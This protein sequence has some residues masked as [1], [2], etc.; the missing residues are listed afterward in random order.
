MSKTD[1]L[2]EVVGE[3]SF[4]GRT[5]IVGYPKPEYDGDLWLV[6]KRKEYGSTVETVIPLTV[7]KAQ[8]LIILL[9]TAIGADSE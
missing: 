1:K 9:Q 6:T 8:D 2:T 7:E 5:T 4:V 3:V